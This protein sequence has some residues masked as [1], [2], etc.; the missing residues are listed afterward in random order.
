MNLIVYVTIAA[1]MLAAAAA[2]MLLPGRKTILVGFISGTLFLPVAGLPF[3][4]LKSKLLIVCATIL[5]ASFLREP[6]RWLRFR[7]KLVD[8]PILAF[9]V[10]PFF[11]SMAN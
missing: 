6:W 5:V 9:C 10:L 2:C 1:W 3:T 8:V 4:G 11:S 7:P